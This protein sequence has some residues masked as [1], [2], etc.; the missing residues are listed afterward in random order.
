MTHIDIKMNEVYVPYLERDEKFQLYYGGSGSG[1]SRFICQKIILMCVKSKRKFLVVR[2]TLASIRESVFAELKSVISDMG[3]YDMVH[4]R[5]NDM[6]ITFPHNE[7]TIIFRGLDDIEKIKSISGITDVFIEEAS[8]VLDKSVFDQLILRVRPGKGIKPHFFLA[9]NPVSASHWLKRFI[10]EELPNKDGFFLK[11]T[12][13]DNMF[14]TQDYIDNLEQLKTTNPHFWRIYGL[15]E[16]GVMGKQ[17]YNGIYDVVEFDDKQIIKDYPQLQSICGLDFGYAADPTAFCHLLVDIGTKQIW[18]NKELYQT[19]MLNNEIAEWIISSGY[20]KSD[21]VA[22]S[23]E[24]KSITEIRGL[25][26][27]RIRGAEKGKGSIN[28]GIDFISQFKIHIHPKCTAFKD[29]IDNY[30]YEKNKEGIYTNKPIDMYNHL[31]DAMRYAMESVQRPNS[32]TF[33]F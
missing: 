29:E 9:W 31:M 3:L 13:V 8:E 11:T 4:I 15:A 14:L 21:I 32:M 25:G 1:K 2:N 6:V 20:S 26:V 10:E 12:Y 24:P 7:S 5:S 17:V 23:A 27:Q 30:S 19:G 18:V 28:S 33:F 16:W 22:D